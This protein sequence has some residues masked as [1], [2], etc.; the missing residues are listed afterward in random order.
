M[1]VKDISPDA[2][3]VWK[4]GFVTLN[5]TILYTWGIMV[6]M[7]LGAWLIT[8]KLST[9]PEVPRWQ[10][11]LEV[12]VLAMRK[13]VR[14]IMGEDVDTYL[15]FIGS[16][17][18]YIAVANLLTILP[19][20][21]PPTASLSTTAGLAI[22]VI[23]AVVIFGVAKG[24]VVGFLKQYL[25]P[26]PV[27]LPFNVIGELSR[28]LALAVRLFGNVMSGTKIV[29]ILLA[30]AP[31]FFPIVMRLLGLLTGLLQAYIF[32][33][34]AAVYIGSAAKAHRRSES[35]QERENAQGGPHG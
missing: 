17:F 11:V 24:G 7:V 16:L 15:P 13:Q 21:D 33:V 9:G 4:W 6:L 26:S 3:V 32:A 20:Y 8:R 27:M 25:Q 1:G 23:S 30:I 2:V 18:L 5:A 19:A 10:N 31:L 35:D 14:A 29:G 22:C 12:V 28:T 34:L